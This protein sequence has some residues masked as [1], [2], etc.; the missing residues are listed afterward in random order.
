MPNA[1]R[2]CPYCN[3]FNR[4]EDAVYDKARNRYFCNETERQ[5]YARNGSLKAQERKALKMIEKIKR[6]RRQ[7][8][9]DSV[10]PMSHWVKLTQRAVNRYV[11]LRDKGKPCISC[12]R[13]EHEFSSDSLRGS[14][15][16]AGHFK[17]VGA[18][19][20]LRF[21]LRNI[22]G[23]CRSCNGFEGGRVADQERGIVAR[24]GQARLDWLDG[25]HPPKNYTREQLKRLRR[26]INKRSQRY[27]W[28]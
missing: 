12:G 15:W 20:E 14:V 25:Y 5:A 8:K 27:E 2:K 1:S 18:H 23:Q 24:F 3:A 19:P 6:V 10:K 17:T 7:E 4:V 21:D 11:R 16:D 13:Y 9:R 28:R 26:L 22:N